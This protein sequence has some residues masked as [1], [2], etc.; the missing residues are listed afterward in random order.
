[1]CDYLQTDPVFAEAWHAFEVS[2]P[3]RPLD[4][5][6]ESAAIGT[7]RYRTVTLEVTGQ[8]GHWIVVQVPHGECAL[9]LRGELLRRLNHVDE[10]P[11]S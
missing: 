10:G 7:F 4:I 8:D 11:R 1:M 3:L 2:T 9:R 6:V 5:A